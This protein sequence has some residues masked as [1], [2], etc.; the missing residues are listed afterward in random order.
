M[1]NNIAVII[2]LSS[3]V[4]AIVAGALLG[5]ANIDQGLVSA[6]TAYAAEMQ[7]KTTLVDVREAEEIALGTPPHAVRFVYRLDGSLDEAFIA[8]ITK[9][10][11]GN[12]SSDVTLM[13][14]TGVRSAAARDL[15]MQNGFR[16]VKSLSGGFVAWREQGLPTDH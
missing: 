4:A 15:L 12:K 14:A 5:V 3:T 13:C 2:G 7:G 6:P 9:L 16:N 1:A 8:E 11:A 10:V